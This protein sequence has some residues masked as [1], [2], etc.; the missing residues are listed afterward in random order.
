MQAITKIAFNYLA[1][2]TG[3]NEPEL[4]F[5]P[6]FNKARDFVRYGA[7]P[8]YQIVELLMINPDS[9]STRNFIC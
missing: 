4:V 2:V 9:T 3:E 7:H 5:N 6:I 8:G 1:Y